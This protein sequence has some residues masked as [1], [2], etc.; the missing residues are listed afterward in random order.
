LVG[1]CLIIKATMIQ[2]VLLI[3][4]RCLNNIWPL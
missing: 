3:E 4:Y 1:Q 2:G